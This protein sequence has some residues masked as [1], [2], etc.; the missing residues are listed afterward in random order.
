MSLVF[1][2]TL[3]GL[4]STQTFR[5]LL[6]GVAFV[7]IM[8]AAFKLFGEAVKWPMLPVFIFF[9]AC[10]GA[11]IDLRQTPFLRSLVWGVG[12]GTVFS[13]LM[14]ATVQ[15]VE[16]IFGQHRHNLAVIEAVELFAPIFAL[17][18]LA[19]RWCVRRELHKAFVRGTA[20]YNEGDVEKRRQI[21]E[22][23]KKGGRW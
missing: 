17:M 8:S 7:A 16:T 5:Q 12:L 13:V 6:A 14:D 9:F 10:I 22:A 15:A 2:R 20:R 4:L 19:M 1:W 21:V 3:L 18:I 11:G 23:F